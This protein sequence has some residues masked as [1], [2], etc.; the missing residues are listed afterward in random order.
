MVAVALELGQRLTE[1]RPVDVEGATRFSSSLFVG[2]LQR[3]GAEL[4]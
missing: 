4:R 1:R 3:L 2:G